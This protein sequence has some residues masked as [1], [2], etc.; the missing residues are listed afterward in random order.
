M[1]IPLDHTA[2]YH[3]ADRLA[4]MCLK[5]LISSMAEEPRQIIERCLKDGAEPIDLFP[6]YQ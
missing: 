5:K 6:H 4:G 1:V 3:Q 2:S